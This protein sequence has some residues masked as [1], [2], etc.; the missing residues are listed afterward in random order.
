MVRPHFSSRQICVR[1]EGIAIYALPLREKDVTGAPSDFPPAMDRHQ[2]AEDR[3]HLRLHEAGVA[4]HPLELRHGG[5]AADR[6]DQI[7]I[8]VLII[9]QQLAERSEERRVG[10]ECVSTGRS[11]WVEYP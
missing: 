5:E 9:G 2:S 6:F 8:A 10:E 11:G 3:L 1:W 4:D 7:A